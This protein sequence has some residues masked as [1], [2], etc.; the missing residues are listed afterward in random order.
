MRRTTPLTAAALLGLTVLAPTSLPAHAAGETC[1]GEAATLVGTGPSLTGT[2]GRDVIVTARAGVVD[3]LG[4]DDLICVT[5][6]VTS[7]NL[8]SIRAGSGADVVDT[9][10]LAPGFYVT[11]VLGAGADTFA[12]G[13]SDDS[14]YAGEQTTGSGGVVLGADTETDTIDTGEDGDY[15]ATGSTGAVNHD[16]VRLGPGDDGM[17]IASPQVAADADLDA[18]DG[19]DTFYL[20]VGETD[21]SLDMA[22]G[23]F[24]TP[25]GTAKAG[26]FE[27]VSLS[28]GSAE[29][30]YRGTAGNDTVTIRPTGTPTLDLATAAGQ[31]QILVEPASIAS[32]SRIDGG[33]GRNELVAA[34]PS[35]T[36]AI[37]L[38]QDQLLI[39]G[40]AIAATG[41]QD[42]FLL[43]PEVTMVGDDGGNN[44]TFVGCRADLTGGAGRDRLRNAFDYYFETYTYDCKARTTMSGESGADTLTGGQAR[45]RMSGGSGNDEIEGRGGNDRIRAGI[46]RDTVDGGEGGDDVRGEAGRDRLD[47]KAGA[48]ILV[49]GPGPDVADGAAGRDR[50]VA[51]RERRCER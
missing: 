19:R 44:L 32:D 43:A 7:S 15:V 30:T 13:R 42:A 24:T 16:V 6:G 50:C 41:L 2:E 5:N 12:G 3:S 14:V 8:L 37:D 25:T 23:T 1:R 33:E 9:T 18:G 29:V 20:D 46:G 45:D 28:V 40:R 49:G 38:E 27:S 26:S 31:D 35:G 51:E 47:G 36:M 34:N 11:T 22:G 39:D 48:D 21:I 4:G 10:A 17:S